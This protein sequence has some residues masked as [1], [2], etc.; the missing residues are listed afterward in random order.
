MTESARSTPTAEFHAVEALLIAAHAVTNDPAY[1]REP[2]GVDA[3]QDTDERRHTQDAC[4]SG[5]GPPALYCAQKIIVGQRRV[6]GRVMFVSQ[7]VG[8]GR[9]VWLPHFW[10]GGY[11]CR[12]RLCG[13]S[14]ARR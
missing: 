3:A 7:V 14:A 6:L 8:C 10:L 13:E 1:A 12:W 11:C 4:L 9:S 5:N 2:L